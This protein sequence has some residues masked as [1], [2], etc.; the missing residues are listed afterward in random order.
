MLRITQSESLQAARE[1]FSDALQPGD[2]YVNDLD[3]LEKVQRRATRMTPAICRLEYQD[4]LKELNMFS[5]K[6]RCLRGD[7]IQ[8]YKIV[9][10]E[11]DSLLH[12][13]FKL[14]TVRG[15]NK[16]LIKEHCRLDIRK[17]FF[18]QRVVNFWNRL[19]P[20]VVNSRSIGIFKSRIDVYMNA[21]DL[22]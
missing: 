9:S 18:S 21:I 6:R 22:W 1:Y 7:M 2:Y 5:I 16:K 17:Y 13:M 20:E 4:R 3:M 14:D 19:P 15:H 12:S 10:G 11:D 8:V